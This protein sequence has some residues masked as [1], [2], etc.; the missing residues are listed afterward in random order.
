MVKDTIFL[1]A[2]LSYF[3]LLVF[4]KLPQANVGT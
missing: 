3:S 4:Y 1:H 2:N